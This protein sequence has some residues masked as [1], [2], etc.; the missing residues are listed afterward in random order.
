[1]FSGAKFTSITCKTIPSV[2]DAVKNATIKGMDINEQ[3]M[4]RPKTRITS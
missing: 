1:M 4:P 2:A 3:M